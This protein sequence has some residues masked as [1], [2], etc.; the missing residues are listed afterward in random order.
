MRARRLIFTAGPW[1]SDWGEQ[2]EP[3][4]VVGIQ[5]ARELLR[6]EGGGGALVAL[7]DGR[8]AL[9]G[10]TFAVGSARALMRHA[11]RQSRC[12]PESDRAWLLTVTE[13][14]RGRSRPTADRSWNMQEMA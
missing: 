14:L 5:V 1:H 3:R 7:A 4:Q 8:F 9:T 2:D 13:E 11:R 10:A 6:R 12:A